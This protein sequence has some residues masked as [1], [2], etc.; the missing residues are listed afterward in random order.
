MAVPVENRRGQLAVRAFASK[1]SGRT[2]VLAWRKG[3]ALR[4]ALGTIATTVQ[5]GLPS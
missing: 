5:K 4:D 3:S 1:D 2:L